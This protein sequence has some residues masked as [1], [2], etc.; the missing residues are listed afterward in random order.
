MPTVPVCQVN[1]SG[2]RGLGQPDVATG[3]GPRSLWPRFPAAARTIGRWAGGVDQKFSL[4]L[5]AVVLAYYV[6]GKLEAN[7][8]QKLDIHSPLDGTVISTVPLST[9][10]DLD[11]AIN[12]VA[13]QKNTPLTAV[14][15]SGLMNVP[16]GE[17]A[18]TPAPRRRCRPARRC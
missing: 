12:Y 13:G 5:L 14:I 15:K 7:G 6:A 1:D 2:Q 16:K 11:K 17:S 10:G 4:E 9:A 18:T 8:Q 3:L